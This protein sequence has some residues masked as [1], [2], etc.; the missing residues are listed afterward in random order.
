MRLA[1]QAVSTNL[2]RA[3]RALTQSIRDLIKAE[4]ELEAAGS[5]EFLQ[6]DAHQKIERHTHQVAIDFTEAVE[7]VNQGGR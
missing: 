6:Y 5:D 1:D 3:A 4:N 2:E 7:A